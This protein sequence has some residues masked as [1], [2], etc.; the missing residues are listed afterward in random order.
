MVPIDLPAARLVPDA[1]LSN[2]EVKS[3]PDYK[4]IARPVKY[5]SKIGNVNIKP[6][7]AT[8]V[9]LVRV[10]TGGGRWFEE[11]LCP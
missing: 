3:L 4:Q 11:D 1:F 7:S 9:F 5:R 6:P 8:A 10:S 2:S